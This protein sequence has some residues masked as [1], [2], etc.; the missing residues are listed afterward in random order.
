MIRT[1]NCNYINHD[2][3]HEQSQLLVMAFAGRLLCHLIVSR[4]STI[5][6]I[7]Y[8]T[9]TPIM[10]FNVDK[11]KLCVECPKFEWAPAKI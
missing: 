4:K 6:M 1:S 11:F 10:K 7:A 5:A 2:F 9:I 3:M 8:A